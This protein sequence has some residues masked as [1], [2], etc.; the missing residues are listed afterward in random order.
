MKKII[1]IIFV[2]ILAVFLVISTTFGG[3]EVFKKFDLYDVSC[4]WPSSFIVQ[5]QGW[6]DPPYPWKVPCFA[7]P[8]EG[9][10]KFYWERFVFDIAFFYLLIMAAYYY[11]KPD[12]EEIQKDK[13]KVILK[14]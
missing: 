14:S 11:W 6:R 2:F 5:D 9:P 1:K 7:S 3:V 8:L 4:G 10:T 12:H 13:N